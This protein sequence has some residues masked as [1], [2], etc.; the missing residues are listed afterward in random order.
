[1]IKAAVVAF[2]PQSPARH[3]LESTHPPEYQVGQAFQPDVARFTVRLESL[4]YTSFDILAASCAANSTATAFA[5]PTRR[6]C[7]ENN[8]W[9]TRYSVDSSDR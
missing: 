4:T 1:M 3:E 8:R 5:S 6:P 9:S 2:P 7:A